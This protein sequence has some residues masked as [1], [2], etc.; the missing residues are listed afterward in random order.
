[1]KKDRETL[2][3]YELVF[4]FKN[5]NEINQKYEKILKNIEVSGF[6]EAVVK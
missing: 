2:L 6:E 4:D 3:L 5:K 1:M